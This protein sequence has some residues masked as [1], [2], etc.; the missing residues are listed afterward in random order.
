MD[1]YLPWERQYK[2][3]KREHWVHLSGNAEQIHSDANK[4][5]NSPPEKQL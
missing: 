3:N 4:Q 1:S 2:Q 5:D